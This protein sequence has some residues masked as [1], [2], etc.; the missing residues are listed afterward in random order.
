ME[1]N[2]KWQKYIG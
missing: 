2:F 1:F